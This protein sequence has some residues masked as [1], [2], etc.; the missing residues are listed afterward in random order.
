MKHTI[1]VLAAEPGCHLEVTTLIIP[2]LND[3]ED[4]IDAAAAWL[5]SLDPGIPYHITRFFPACR[6]ATPRRPLP[7]A[8]W[9]P[10][11]AATSSTSTGETARR[12][13]WDP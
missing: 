1:A 3:G 2:G 8:S 4:E 5:A 10:Q 12:R 7:C 11:P 9:P 6:T 13:R